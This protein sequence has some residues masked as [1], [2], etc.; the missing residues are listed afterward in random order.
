MNSIGCC[1]HNSSL[2]GSINDPIFVPNIFTPNGDD[3]NDIFY[4]RGNS[5]LSITNFEIRDK[6]EDIVFR[7]DYIDY[8]HNN[9]GWDGT[10]DGSIKKGMYDYSARIETLDGLVGTVKDKICNYPCSTDVTTQLTDRTNC[11]FDNTWLCFNSGFI[12]CYLA[13][14]PGCFN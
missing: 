1:D 6:F 12:D 5:I 4:I 10:V 3:I 7:V 11:R 8:E 14:D 2:V 9:T 13:E